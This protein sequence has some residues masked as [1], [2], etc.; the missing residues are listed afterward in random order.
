MAVILRRL[1]QKVSY[2]NMQLIAGE[3]GLDNLVRWIHP[4]ESR[5]VVPFVEE[6]EVVFTTG[7]GL[8]EDFDLLKLVKGVEK[9][10]AAGIVL[11]TGP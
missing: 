5:E 8:T 6:G 3:N 2:L 1:Y 11:N 10:G 4:V 9:R 7:L